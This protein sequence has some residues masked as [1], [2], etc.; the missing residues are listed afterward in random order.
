MR[1]FFVYIEIIMKYDNVI[2]I[3]IMFVLRYK[4]EKM[5]KSSLFL[6]LKLPK[7][8]RD[9]ATY[10]KRINHCNNLYKV[11]SVKVNIDNY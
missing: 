9:A 1:F 10:G 8:S 11:F 6:V 3:K 4:W 7:I 5:L 2:R